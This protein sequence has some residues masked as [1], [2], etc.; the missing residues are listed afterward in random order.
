MS[1]ALVW[2]ASGAVAKILAASGVS[3]IT[4]ICYRAIFVSV[5]MGA[6]L[7][8][9]RGR[10]LFNLSG[11]MCVAYVFLGM[12][13]MANAAGYMMACVYLSIPQALMIIYT[14]PIATMA[15]SS[16]VTGEKPGLIQVI[17]GFA[18]L[19]GLYVGFVSGSGEPGDISVVGVAWSLLSVAALAGQAL[20]S[21]RVT[22][23]G[24]SDAMCQ[25]FYAHVFG[26]MI[27]IVLKSVL[28]GWSD[29]AYITPRVFVLM[30]QP[31]IMAALLGYG[32]FFASLKYIPAS[33][34]SLLCT[35]EIVFALLLLP[36]LLNVVPPVN[37][38][39]GCGII[40]AA[41]SCSI[42]KS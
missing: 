37:E 34:G 22:K 13:V 29:V 5:L 27:I 21:R 39:I 42:L 15:G 32:L 10:E 17:S 25:L 35:T 20:I 41:V 4:V 19:V 12:C 24:H 14:Y 3:Q 28:S 31:A 1:A 30:Q 8:A 2:S 36:V 33:L 26:G 40:L 38:V 23:S 7:Y 9:K 11:G 18:V 6:Y 16:I